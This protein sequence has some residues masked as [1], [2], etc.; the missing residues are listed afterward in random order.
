MSGLECIALLLGVIP[1]LVSCAEH[2]RTVHRPIRAAVRP[3]AAAQKLADFFQDLH[4]EVC[5]L[6]LHVRNLARELPQL[7]NSQLQSLGNFSQPS[8]WDDK[9]VS[10]ALRDRLGATYEP[11]LVTIKASLKILDDLLSGQTLHNLRAHNIN[12]NQP[13]EF[14]KLSALQRNIQHGENST[15]LLQRIQFSTREDKRTRLLRR[16]ERNNANMERLLSQASPE[17][18]Q[19][20]TKRRSGKTVPKRHFWKLL[21]ALYD[22][23][24]RQLSCGCSSHHQG[25]ICLVNSLYTSLKKSPS[26][27]DLDMLL[28]RK[29]VE[30]SNPRKWQESSIAIVPDSFSSQPRLCVRFA[31]GIVPRPRVDSFIEPASP[32]S[33]TKERIDNICELLEFAQENNC[34]LRMQYNGEQL[35]QVN[36][37]PKRLWGLESG[38]AVSLGDFLRNTGKMTL[39]QKRIL[40]VILAHTMLQYCG[41]PWMAEDWN[42]EHIKFFHQTIERDGAAKLDLERPYLSKGFV[43]SRTAQG[44]SSK[45]VLHPCSSVLALGILLLEI[46]LGV[47]IESKRAD[48]DLNGGK[49]NAN[50]DLFTASRILEESHDNMYNSYFKIIQACI[51][52]KFLVNLQRASLGDEEV[53]QAVYDE[54]V[55]PLEEELYTAWGITVD[56]LSNSNTKSAENVLGP[57]TF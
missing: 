44:G 46:E 35:W 5:F 55:V 25:R 12:A 15:T 54:I 31:D 56:H 29:H 4:V 51:D 9:E 27:I 52:C 2:Y 38:R 48:A 26:S 20:R 7:S 36:S 45:Y 6:E 49:V 39:K 41:S 32:D 34:S 14:S 47:P 22:A 42:K 33:Q 16:L 43:T 18:P 19:S 53:R 10:V 23:M 17:A 11:I 28:S 21:H 8:N 37:K 3:T 57:I 1:I 40:A 24:T 50:T 13:N 30:G